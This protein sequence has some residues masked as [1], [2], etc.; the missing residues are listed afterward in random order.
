MSLKIPQDAKKIGAIIRWWQPLHSG[1]KSDD[2]LIDGIRINGEEINP[3]N[4]SLNFT[5][6]FELLDVI[7]ADNME[8]GSYCGKEGVAIGKTKAEEPSTLTSRDVTV[9]DD[10]ILQFSINVGC[11]KPWDASVMS[12]SSML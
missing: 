9:K 7:T 2:W 4:F 10:H 1:E 6:G 11:G 5:K 3:E 12:V 8:I